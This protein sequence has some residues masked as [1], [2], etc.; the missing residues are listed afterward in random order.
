MEKKP[1]VFLDSGVGGLPYFFEAKKKMPL[2]DYVYLADNAHFPYGGRP[3][4]S[5]IEIV[6][7]TIGRVVDVFDPEAVVIACNTASVVTLSSLRQKYGVPFIGVVPAIKPAAAHTE[8]GIIGLL[9]T[10]TTVKSMYTDNLIRN[11]A[12]SCRVKKFAGVQI[13]DFVENQYFLAD[14]KD[15]RKMMQPAVAFFL[16]EKIDTLILGCTH[17]LFVKSILQKMLGPQIAV[18]DSVEGVVNQLSRVLPDKYTGGRDVPSHEFY[19]TG[20][21][22]DES[23]YRMFA[24][25][26]ELTWGG[27]L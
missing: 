19:I 8:N 18:I 22:F 17:F 15:V 13:V 1:V 3:V 7:E 9:A 27:S 6:H 12:S 2:R 10:E 23:R 24:G 21:T 14:E 5:L 4:Q 20:D 25:R 16:K 26:F 11:F